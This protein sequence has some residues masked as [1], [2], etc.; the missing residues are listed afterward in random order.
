MFNITFSENFSMWWLAMILAITLISIPAFAVD[1]RMQMT[2][3]SFSNACT[4]ADESW[5]SFCNG[6]IQAVVDSIPNNDKICIPKGTSRTELVTITE[7]EITASSKL[8]AINANN[9]VLTVLRNSY[10][11]Q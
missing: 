5:V 8:R 9:A 1:S 6:Y 10:P 3:E 11:C 2:G 7:K 4:R